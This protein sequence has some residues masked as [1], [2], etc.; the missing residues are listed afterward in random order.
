MES[1]NMEDDS[2]DSPTLILTSEDCSKTNTQSPSPVKIKTEVR[3][4]S[5]SLPSSQ[6]PRKIAISAEE[7]ERLKARNI[8]SVKSVKLN[9]ATEGVESPFGAK[10]AFLIKV[11]PNCPI[12]MLNVD[13]VLQIETLEESAAQRKKSALNILKAVKKMVDD[14]S[15]RDLVY[16][17]VAS[18]VKAAFPS[19][20]VRKLTWG[21]RQYEG[22]LEI[23]RR[24][25]D[26]YGNECPKTGAQVL[27]FAKS[28]RAELRVLE[29]EESLISKSVHE[30]VG[31]IGGIDFEEFDKM[32]SHL[33]AEYSYCAGIPVDEVEDECPLAVL[34]RLPEH[35]VKGKLGYRSVDCAR[36]FDRMDSAGAFKPGG[37]EIGNRCE[38]CCEAL[39]RGTSRS[40]TSV[41]TSHDFGDSLELLSTEELQT[42]I[43]DLNAKT[44]NLLHVKRRKEK[45][46]KR[47][48]EEAAKYFWCNLCGEKFD[49]NPALLAHKSTHQRNYKCAICDKSFYTTQML[50]GHER[51]HSEERPYKCSVCDKGFLGQFALKQHTYVHSDEKLF[52]CEECDARFKTNSTLKSHV[53]RR[54]LELQH[55][56][57]YCARSFADKS[58]LKMHIMTHTGEKPYECL[59]CGW[60]YAQK[61]GL[62]KHELT[63]VK[64]RQKGDNFTCAICDQSF[65]NSNLLNEHQSKHSVKPWERPYKCENCPLTF[66]NPRRLMIHEATH[67][68]EKEF[69][70]DL[71]DCG[72]VFRV[73]ANLKK[74]MCLHSNELPFQCQYCSKTFSQRGYVKIHE[75]IHTGEKP[76]KCGVENC[77]KSFVQK[78]GLTSHQLSI[79]AK[80]TPF[81]CE[82]C[83]K[84]FSSPPALRDHVRTH[85]GEKP[86]KCRHCDVCFTNLGQRHSHELRHTGT[87][88][89]ACDHCAKRFILKSDLVK[90]VRTHT[91]ERPFKCSHCDARFSQ[92]SSM[93]SHERQ[94]TN[95]NESL[96]KCGKCSKTFK[97]KVTL[98]Q[99]LLTIHKC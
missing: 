37:V 43:R 79:H 21:D 13:G 4:L 88:R 73:R 67:N 61:G 36:W 22:T 78:S 42:R 82:H 60:Q 30:K 75:R 35:L 56:C 7:F 6:S 11:E 72:K 59:H 81:R 55:M 29:V 10:D 5:N 89:F 34:K 1:G 98:K 18:H 70:C 19:L 48:A 94:H 71:G 39:K 53:K 26:V 63:H 44:R 83:R 9:V 12:R 31:R 28:M 15:A 20:Q 66:P 92:Q 2:K 57:E 32:L 38:A 95:V 46:E 84:M 93:K 65:E 99:H 64:G 17:K 23:T 80:E 97:Q 40:Q 77:R 86:Y 54:H 47:F 16:E 51:I 90:H 3:S 91:G 45:E 96:F 52:K 25:A 50:K 41:E 58:H 49:S 68:D 14:R 24:Q 85:T 8:L 76:Y 74:H 62:K 87:K 33:S 27:L 69:V